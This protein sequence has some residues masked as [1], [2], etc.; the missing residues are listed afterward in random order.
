[1]LIIGIAGGT[2]SGKTTFAE[3]IAAR[4]GGANIAVISQDSYYPDRSHLSIEEREEIN[5][6][7]PDSFENHLLVSHLRLLQQ[8]FDAEIPEYDFVDHIR[9]CGVRLLHPSPIVIVEGLLV[10]AIEAIRRETDLKLFI[11]TD[12]DVRLT[13]RIM[14]DITERGRTLETIISRYLATVKPM[15]E[16]FVEPSKRYADLIIPRGSENVAALDLICSELEQYLKNLQTAPKGPE[17]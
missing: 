14:R 16:A 17:I 8:G 15:H 7:H 13:R 9:T 10:L 11:D 3:N 4:L 2:G 6:D 5:F 12:A 1:M